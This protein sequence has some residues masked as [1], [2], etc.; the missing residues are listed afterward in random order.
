MKYIDHC[1]VCRGTQSRQLLSLSNFPIYQNPVQ[2]DVEVPRPHTIDLEYLQ[3]RD[4]GHAFQS[5]YGSATLKTIYEHY[6]FVPEVKNVAV[7]RH[8]AFL[9]WL[10]NCALFRKNAP[11]RIL[12]IGCSSGGVLDEVRALFSL[13]KTDVLGIEPNRAT[14]QAA[15]RL[16]LPIIENFCDE[17]L[18]QR[19]ENFD[20]VFSRNVIEHVDDPLSFLRGMR[21]AAGEHGVVIIETP[22]LDI[23]L[24]ERKILPFHFEHL[25]VF[26]AQ[27]L[28]RAAEEMG[29]VPIDCVETEF[30][31]LI[32]AFYAQANS[33]QKTP[34]TV[35]AT[36]TT[37]DLQPSY[38]AKRAWWQ[39]QLV[40]Q[41]VIFW[42]AGSACRILIADTNFMP[43]AICDSNPNKIGMKFVGLPYRIEP[44]EDLIGALVTAGRDG[45]YLLVAASMFQEEIRQAARRLGW[46]GKFLGLLDG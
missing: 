22:S 42:G 6:Y 31:D 36:D 26:S 5:A 38:D 21:K 33:S 40:S 44:A 39:R 8:H 46:S 16:G 19:V 20:L 45:E 7:S 43:E 3:C 29:L 18:M 1:P 41:K 13:E 12:E 9:S 32:M 17:S 11:R 23:S 30:G 35:A 25:H 28:A 10:A 15:R 34:L 14:A 4:C 27:S 24:R 2:A 37:L